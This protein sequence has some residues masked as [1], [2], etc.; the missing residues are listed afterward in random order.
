MPVPLKR[1]SATRCS[2]QNGRNIGQDFEGK[3][4]WRMK[5][6]GPDNFGHMIL[7]NLRK[8]GVQN[9]RQGERL[10]FDSVDVYAGEWIHGVGIYAEADGTSNAISIRM[11]GKS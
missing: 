11:D 9:T 8:A 7:E 10:K 1:L 3:D 6:I 4:G 5:M 2:P